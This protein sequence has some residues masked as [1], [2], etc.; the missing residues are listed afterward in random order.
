MAAAPAPIPGQTT[1]QPAVPLTAA[2]Q[3]E[4]A[5]ERLSILETQYKPTHPD[6]LALR[7]TVRELEAKAETELKQP[8]SP[9][10]ASALANPVEAGRQ[11]RIRE[12]KVQIEDVDR[13]LADKQQQEKDLRAV[14][15]NYQAKLDA[16]PIR[17]SDLVEL[18]RD[19]NTL[20]ATYQSL[21]T[22]REES[23]LAAS[24]ERRSIG[25][26]FRVLDPARVPERPFSPN[27]IMITLGGAGGGL[28]LGLL[29]VGFKEY[30]ESSLKTE[31]DV[32]RLCQLPV[33]ASVPLM[34]S[35]QERLATRRRSMLKHLAAAVVVLVCVAV[36]ALSMLPIR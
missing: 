20:Q 9:A 15:A 22:K 16:V 11:K 29:L 28:V 12:L 21:L 33:I 31:Q 18:T 14:V 1:T 13:E 30:R 5:R 6:I 36:I 35:A 17:E 19:Y 27:L 24:L 8:P 10:P 4:A 32:M 26:Q 25:E 34:V 3:L 7:R 2:Q 23:N